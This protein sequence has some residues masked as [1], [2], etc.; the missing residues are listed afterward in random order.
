[1]AVFDGEGGGAIGIIKN[2]LSP[3]DPESLKIKAPQNSAVV[4]HEQ[5][6]LVD[7]ARVFHAEPEIFIGGAGA[8]V[9]PFD[10]VVR[11]DGKRTRSGIVVRVQVHEVEDSIFTGINQRVCLSVDQC[12]GV[13]E[14]EVS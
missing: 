6:P 12:R 14:A 10:D 9:V 11:I 2:I 4:A 7:A 8:P 5:V 13:E 3:D 1:M